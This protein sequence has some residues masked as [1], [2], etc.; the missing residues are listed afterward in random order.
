MVD[1]VEVKTPS[2]FWPL[3]CFIFFLALKNPFI[4]LECVGD[5]CRTNYESQ[6][7]GEAYT[8]W[9]NVTWMQ[10][11]GNLTVEMLK[12]GYVD[13]GVE[14]GDC[15]AERCEDWN[16]PEMKELDDKLIEV[17]LGGLPDFVYYECYCQDFCTERDE[18]NFIS[19]PSA[20][21]LCSARA[22]LFPGGEVP[23]C[24]ADD[25][26]VPSVPNHIEQMWIS[27]DCAQMEADHN[28]AEGSICNLV[29][30]FKFAYGV[31]V[32][33]LILMCI[34]QALMIYL[35][36]VNFNSF[37]DGKC[38]CLFCPFIVK[39]LIFI[40]FAV[41]CFCM[42]GFVFMT[43]RSG[44]EDALN[45]YF[46]AVNG[47]FEYNWRA[48][49]YFLWWATLIGSGTTILSMIFLMPKIERQKKKS[50]RNDIHGISAE[51]LEARKF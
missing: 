18:N 50:Y 20:A 51:S 28:A 36:Y 49:G 21:D 13:V 23:G 5:H 43:L 32:G 34:L 35:E 3:T 37:M 27:M 15:D 44:V 11:D 47:E 40:A 38:R 9:S 16:Y 19:L 22:P 39:K 41:L 7:N 46:D 24:G 2:F 29:D 25:D 33:T 48:R 6:Y 4:K 8:N 17:D 42:Q 26:P 1:G 14:C 30:L 31:S 10:S 45:D 12:H